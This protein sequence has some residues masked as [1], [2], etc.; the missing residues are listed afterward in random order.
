FL[1]WFPEAAYRRPP[2]E[3]ELAELRAVYDDVV[4]TYGE[5]WAFSAL[6]RAVLLSP[7]F[8]YRWEVGPDGDGVVELSDYEIASLIAFSLTDA[9]PDAALLAD[10]AA[11]KLRDPAV[12]E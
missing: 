3:H 11:G 8:L 12:R 4:G 5:E 1:A 2:S 6:V 10:A 9:G 7:Q